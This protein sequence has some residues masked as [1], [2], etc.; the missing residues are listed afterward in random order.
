MTGPPRE[1]NEAKPPPLWRRLVSKHPFRRGSLLIL[2]V[3]V[4]EYLVLPQIAG[5]GHSLQLLRRVNIGFVVLA[6]LLEVASLASYAELTKAVLP[7]RA[8]RFSRIWR[9]DLSTLAVSHVLPGGTAGGDGLGYRLLTNEGVSGG[10]AGLALAIQGIGS[11]LVLNAILWLALIVS[12]PLTGFNPIYATAAIVG[13]LLLAVFAALVLLLTKGEERAAVALKNLVTRLPFLK[14]NAAD[15]ADRLLHQVAARIRV[16]AA[17]HSLLRRA[18]LWA[19][20]NWLLDAASLFVFL[21]AFGKI[22]NPDGLLV[23]YG[24]AYVLAAI[25]VT[26]GGLGVVEGVLVPSL[27]GF[28]A[29]RAIAIVAVIGYRLVNFWLPIPVGAGCYLSLAGGGI[30]ASD[31]RQ[32]LRRAVADARSSTP[33]GLPSD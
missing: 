25:P 19:A 33:P 3:L 32:K 18:V 29:T 2:L 17:D 20:A 10:D 1:P 28:G 7:P 24:L 9:I 16:M 31:R 26:P 12:I 6:V 27:V 30:R 4:V 11:A 8:S 15:T 5:L 23:A 22:E 13:A 14:P 21:A